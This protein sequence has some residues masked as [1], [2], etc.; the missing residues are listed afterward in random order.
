MHF[1]QTQSSRGCGGGCGE[2]WG[3]KGC[4][5]RSP[6]VCCCLNGLVAILGGEC[7]VRDLVEGWMHGGMMRKND[8]R[9]LFLELFDV[10]K[11]QRSRGHGDMAEIENFELET[12]MMGSSPVVFVDA[13]ASISCVPGHAQPVNEPF[14]CVLVP[15]R[16][17]RDVRDT[18]HMQPHT[19]AGPRSR[20]DT[21]HI[22]KLRGP[23]ISPAG[24]DAM[25]QTALPCS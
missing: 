8:F 23:C 13:G 11:Q 15:P 1:D 25:L 6:K 17:L 21:R 18:S 19:A 3:R 10:T 7:W 4:L 14:S 22:R 16:R 24:A 12:Q 2:P 20:V 9:L 5:R